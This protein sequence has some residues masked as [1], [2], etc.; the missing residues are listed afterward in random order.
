[1]RVVGSRVLSELIFMLLLL[2]PDEAV[3]KRLFLHLVTLSGH[4]GFTT[5]NSG[6]FEN[7][8][9]DGNVHTSL[10]LDDISYLDEVVLDF[11]LDSIS[12]D[13]DLEG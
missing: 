11:L 12:E 9:V 5:H 3:F 2:F 13:D 1:M 4:S 8:S 7:N 6:T 10:D